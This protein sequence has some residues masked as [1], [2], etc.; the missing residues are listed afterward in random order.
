[1][2]EWAET[3][4]RL[5][6]SVIE[7]CETAFALVEDEHQQ[8]KLQKRAARGTRRASAEIERVAKNEGREALFR[9]LK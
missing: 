7:I 1:M 4:L 8:N 6:P 9:M 2:P 5:G 3:L